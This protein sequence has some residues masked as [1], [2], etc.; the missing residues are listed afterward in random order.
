MI[1]LF[2][3]DLQF[4]E[5]DKI[6]VVQIRKVYKKYENVC[7]KKYLYKNKLG[8]C[9]LFKGI[10]KILFYIKSIVIYVF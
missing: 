2:L 8:F 1:L 10:N 9:N 3:N 7:N 4:L 5:F 6:F